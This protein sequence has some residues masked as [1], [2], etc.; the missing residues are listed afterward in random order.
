[1]TDDGRLLEQ[2]KRQGSQAAFSALVTR[3]LNFVYSVCLRETQNAALA[4]D[5]TQVVFLLLSRKAPS[6]GPDTRLT[7]WLFQT[8]RF[9]CK[10][11][12]RRDASR[13]R[14]EQKVGEQM[15]SESQGQD[16]LWEQVA[17]HLNAALTSLGAKDREAVLLRFADGLSFSEL[18]TALGTSEDAARMRVSRALTRLRG[19]FA[20]QG[21]SVTA[22]VL[23]GLLA[24]RTTQAAPA[25]CVISLG[26][27][28]ASAP[29]PQV[30]MQLQGA[31]KTMT[32]VKLKLA[33]TVGVGAMLVGA[34][35]FVTLAQVQ[36]PAL[37]VPQS[38]APRPMRDQT[39]LA[40]IEQ[41]ARA[42][43]ALHS[44]SADTARGDSLKFQRPAQYVSESPGI[45]GQTSIVNGSDFWFYTHWNKKYQ[46]EH[47]PDIKADRIGLPLFSNFFF[48]PGLQGLVWYTLKPSAATEV[49]LLGTRQWHG[50]TYTAVQVTYPPAPAIALEPKDSLI[51]GTLIAYFGADHLLHGY[52]LDTLYRGK[53]E[54][55][56]DLLK[57][58][59]VN[60]K[61][62]DDEFLWT[63]PAGASPSDPPVGGSLHP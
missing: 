13:R 48:N 29:S 12:L 27:L 14:R 36:K 5:V 58:L 59:R 53:K 57:N 30:S 62:A 8:A 2:W 41:A 3:H 63:P 10:N 61:F 23:T 18:G 19:F 47:K 26:K 6:F 42:T 32:L 56:E 40:V 15:L 43:A 34:I 4:E 37:P 28:G 50:G 60:P 55:N 51:S 38:I 1:M 44:L 49:H 33:A 54:I 20:K 25:S 11:A 24:D 17:P 39:G 22:L 31:I 21:V 7:G 52:H 35:P 45:N 46:K 16:A 9:A